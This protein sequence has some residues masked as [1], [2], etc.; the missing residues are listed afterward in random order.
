VA[1][2]VV[3]APERVAAAGGDSQILNA[4]PG[5]KKRTS[6]PQKAPPPLTS[7]HTSR[8]HLKTMSTTIS[9]VAL[10]LNGGC[11]FA[12]AVLFGMMQTRLLEMYGVEVRAP[13]GRLF[14]APRE[15]PSRQHPTSSGTQP[16][17]SPRTPLSRSVISRRLT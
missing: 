3:D 7:A 11:C 8:H 9:S 2:G 14:V 5:F 12:Y 10:G 6:S 16:S 15:L 17:L 13:S 4:R 1:G